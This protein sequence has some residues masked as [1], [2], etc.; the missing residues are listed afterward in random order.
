MPEKRRPDR[1]GRAVAGRTQQR[2]EGCRVDRAFR[3]LG[4]FAAGA[5]SRNSRRWRVRQCNAPSTLGPKAI[6]VFED[7]VVL[8]V[9]LAQCGFLPRGETAVLRRLRAMRIRRRDSR[10][11]RSRT[12]R[13]TSD[14]RPTVADPSSTPRRTVP[15][16]PRARRSS[17]SWRAAKPCCRGPRRHT[18]REHRQ[19]RRAAPRRGSRGSRHPSPGS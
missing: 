19:R 3:Q 7:P 9:P 5:L 17:S 16:Q 14:P 13:E 1:N 15:R 2:L 4:L 18:R 6:A 12:R 10:R 11:A 8:G